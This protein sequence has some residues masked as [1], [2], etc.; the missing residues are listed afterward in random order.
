VRID[1]GDGA[2]CVHLG[3]ACEHPPGQNTTTCCP[4]L[5]I[6]STSDA[7]VHNDEIDWNSA[8]SRDRCHWHFNVSGRIF[9]NE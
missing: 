5:G 8:W 4:I 9:Q 1:V 2:I 7:A 3:R 6:A